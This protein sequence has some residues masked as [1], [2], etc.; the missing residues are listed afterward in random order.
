MSGNNDIM[1]MLSKM[2]K[3]IDAIQTSNSEVI[4]VVGG[5]TKEIAALKKE[6]EKLKIENSKLRKE[7]AVIK[8]SVHNIIEARRFKNIIIHVIIDTE[9]INVDLFRTVMDKI[10]F[11]GIEDRQVSAI[12]RIG[13]VSGNRPIAVSLVNPRDKKLFFDN[14]EALKKKLG[15]TIATDQ[16]KEKRGEYKKMKDIVNKFSEMNIETKIF[17]SKI[18]VQGKSCS[19]AQAQKMLEKHSSSASEAQNDDDCG[20][21]TAIMNR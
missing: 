9:T 8:K 18:Q 19:V 11:I 13:F 4:K 5:H 12:R 21:R 16:S 2:D 7:T 20:K 3:K 1:K 14:Q 10:N 17:K 6:N 15:I